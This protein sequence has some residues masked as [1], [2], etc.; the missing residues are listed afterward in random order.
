MAKEE[1]TASGGA[2]SV[3]SWLTQFLFKNNY[4]LTIL[5]LFL[6]GRRNLDPLLKRHPNPSVHRG[7]MKNASDPGEAVKDADA[8]VNPGGLVGGPACSRGEKETWLH[9]AAT[10]NRL[11]DTCNYYWTKR[12]LFASSRGVGGAA[13]SSMS[14]NEG[15]PYASCFAPIAAGQFAFIKG[16]A[17]KC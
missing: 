5:D 15:L 17:W 7:D 8:V 3:R 13:P 2:G 16:E 9:N 11:V 4:N 6:F 12:L 14:L 1:V 10:T